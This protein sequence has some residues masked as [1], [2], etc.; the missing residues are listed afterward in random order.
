MTSGILQFDHLRAY[1]AKTQDLDFA[2]HGILDRKSSIT[3]IL[4]SDCFKE[5]KM[6]KKILKKNRNYYF[7]V[8][9]VHIQ[10]KVKFL[11]ILDCHF[12][13]VTSLKKSE[14]N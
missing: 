1:M 6:K 8:I 4:L 10:A 3:A 14:E 2:R 9:L 7:W 12:L 13:G 5:N 11:Q